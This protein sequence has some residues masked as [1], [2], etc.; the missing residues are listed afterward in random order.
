M[1]V[2]KPKSKRV[3][4]RLRHKIQKASAAKQRKNRKEEKTNPTWRSRLKKDPGIPN[5]FPYKAKLLAEIEESK[6]RKEEEQMQ[7]REVAKARREGRAVEAQVSSTS[8]TI[9]DEDLL[10]EDELE[11]G[12]VSID[13]DGDEEMEDDN[14][15]PMAALFA[16]AQAMAQNYDAAEEDDDS[17]ELEDEEQEES[18]VTAPKKE[19]KS[20]SKALP[21]RALEDPIKAV[22]LLMTQMQATPDGVQ[23]LLDHYQVPPLVIAS[24]DL[25]TRTLVEVARKR[26]RL[27]RGGVPNLHAAA[28]IIL[29]DLHEQRL[30]LP[31]IQKATKKTAKGEVSIVK[32]MAAPF[33]LEGL[34]GDS[35]AEAAAQSEMAVDA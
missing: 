31:A 13:D 19:A 16:S 34:W 32:T 17:E 15:N 24:S 5:L 30:R 25:T 2:G 3:P 8:Q 22:T 33:R 28:L 6:R 11:D 20:S 26:G 1:K 12:G 23:T 18:A 29:S 14:K 27:G 4:V 21:K 9:A 10:D 7:K 35:V